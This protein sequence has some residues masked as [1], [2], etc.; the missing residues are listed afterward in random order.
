[1]SQSSESKTEGHPEHFASREESQP[2][3]LRAESQ[4]LTPRAESQPLT[5]REEEWRGPLW[6]HPFFLYVALT[7]AL[8]LF[9]LVMG[10]LAWTQDWI[11]HR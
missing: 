7:G 1:M 8:F 5:P 9:L 10:W 2:L 11:P 6:K 4:P 3:T